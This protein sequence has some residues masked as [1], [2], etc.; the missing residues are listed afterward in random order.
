MDRFDSEYLQCY[1][2][3]VAFSIYDEKGMGMQLR[4]GFKA[5]SLCRDLHRKNRP[6]R[7]H[8]RR[9]IRHIYVQV[10]A[11]DQDFPKGP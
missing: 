2:E 9:M 5:E 1:N 8:E 7:E 3:S 11:N 4:S 6:M 10:H